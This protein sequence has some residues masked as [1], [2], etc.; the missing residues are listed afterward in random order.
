MSDLLA[1]YDTRLRTEAE[2]HGAADVER[3][4]PLWI[5]RFDGG[6]LFVTYQELDDPVRRVSE[7]AA[8]L[9]EDD[10]I[11]NA[12]WKTRTHDHAPG[13]ADALTAAGFVA[14]EAESVMLGDASTL[15]AAEVPDGVTVRKVTTPDGIRAALDMQ[16]SV[17]G[18]DPK[19]ER[20]LPAILQ[21]H[22]D[23]GSVEVWVAEADGLIVSA[24]RIEPVVGTAFAG[25]WGGATLPEYRGRGIYRA[26]TAARV[27][28]MMSRGV[29]WI[30]SD[31]TE[32]SRPILERAGL[33]KVTETVPWLWERPA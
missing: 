23:G 15:V 4:G 5:A 12:E 14:D 32:A 16:D 9:A 27:R 26:L 11:R 30:H 17:F 33:V 6:H 28:S 22:R 10:S 3:R 19:A 31:S 20:M 2:M 18:G 29:R 21:Q 25:V 7:V 1:E 24:G 13:L 8:L